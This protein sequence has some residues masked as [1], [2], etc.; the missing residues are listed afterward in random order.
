MFAD[1]KIVVV[2][3]AYNAERTLDKTYKEI[4]KEVVDEV[5]LVDDRSCDSTVLKAKE[6]GIATY[7]HDINK[8]YGGNQKTCYREALKSGADIVIMLHP[9]YQYP[10]K[11]IPTL[12][13]LLTSGM[14]DVALGSRIL[15]G[16]ALKGGMPLY[17]YISNRALTFFD[18]LITGQKLSEYHTGY[19][20]FT[21]EILLDLPLLEN[22]DDFIFDNE[23]LMQA[24]YF[25]Y[26][27]GEVTCPTNYNKEASS[28]S[29][30]RSVVY[31]IGILLI[32]VKFILQKM[33]LAKF[34]IFNPH[35]KKIKI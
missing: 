18:N 32:G 19:R 30:G 14:F 8:G 9:D 28:I 10:P 27:I 22:S 5:L 24:A 23:M 2:M 15:G 12:A 7:I 3:P 29:F 34:S 16:M 25:G 26:R 13:G 20:A 33:K 11:L 31:G 35:G 4:P 21:R 17:K 1:K 6:L